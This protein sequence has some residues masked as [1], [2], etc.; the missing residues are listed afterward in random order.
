MLKVSI[1]SLPS[2]IELAHKSNNNVL[3]VGN[4][5]VGKS[6]VIEAM[7]SDKVRVTTM[8]GS[9]T[10]EEY[11]N[12]I[13]QVSKSGD[14]L[15]YISPRWFADMCEW[16]DEHTDADEYQ[17]LFLDEFNTADPQVLKTFLTILSERRI[18]TLNK[19]LPDHVVLVAAMNPNDQNDTDKLIRPM[20]SRFMVLSIESDKA[21]YKNYIE[22]VAPSPV[23]GGDE[24]TNE[25]EITP[26]QKI[27]IL[28]QISD[29]EWNRFQDEGEGQYHEINA[30]SVTNFFR[31]L[32]MAEDRETNC[33]RLAY[34]FLGKKLDWV[35]SVE[36]R[37]E[38]R[39]DKIARGDTYATL[40]E[41]RNMSLDMLK[42]YDETLANSPIKNADK[43]RCRT[44]IRTVIR[45]KEAIANE[46]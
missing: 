27:A 18:P 17:I 25:T 36:K 46:H 13:P 3:V 1:A 32:S 35:E 10:I 45:E 23:F 22:G 24:F 19:S 8:T 2:V 41:L 33:P 11:V 14:V 21:A 5:G 26:E 39:A 4:P 29:G 12:G 16:A 15:E 40:E 9:S 42:S 6:S 43:R 30:R 38:E 44:N 34:A 31:A 20:A 28:D 37:A 7:A